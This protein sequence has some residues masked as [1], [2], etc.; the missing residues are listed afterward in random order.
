MRLHFT[1]RDTGVG[2]APE[3]QEMIFEAFTQADGSTTRKF[4]GTGLGLTI[5]ARLV[6]AMQGRT[7][8]RKRARKGQPLPFH[9]ILW[10]FSRTTEE[11]GSR[12]ILGRKTGPGGRR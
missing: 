5:S 6:E 9:G 4:G 12:G 11:Q 1:V 8:G 10:R 3:K 7:L 2:I